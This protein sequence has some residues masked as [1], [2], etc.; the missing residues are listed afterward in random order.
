MRS[1]RE[2]VD[3]HAGLGVEHLHREHPGHAEA[4][5]DA[6]GDGLSRHR[7]LLADR[8][9][10]E[11]LAADPLD[12][13]RLDDR[14]DRGLPVRAARDEHRQLAAELDPLLREQGVAAREPLPRLP[15]TVDHPHALA[16]IAAAR[17]LQHHR[18]ADLRTERIHRSGVRD[19]RP[20]RARNA[21][22]GQPGAHHRLVLCVHECIR[23]RAYD[24]V[25]PLEPAQV[26][27]RHVL[28]VEG[29]HVAA[30]GEGPQRV[31]IAFVAH[32]DVGHDLPGA[33]RCVTGEHPQPDP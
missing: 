13:H 4:V 22:L 9:R 32:V 6:Q 23:T 19:H 1:H 28:V 26:V 29:Q 8:G 33:V 17:G 27:R 21:E 16:V 14:V 11:Y 18:P 31:E 3:E 5:G 15:R 30:L 12:L 7:V 24:D 10:R 20:A 2:L 25:L